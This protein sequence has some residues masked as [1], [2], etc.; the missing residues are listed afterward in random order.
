MFTR[1]IFV[2]LGEFAAELHLP[3][4]AVRRCAG[5]ARIPLF[6]LPGVPDALLRRTD[7]AHLHTL[8]GT[9]G[10]PYGPTAA[11]D[12]PPI[13]RLTIATVIPWNL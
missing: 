11:S 13:R 9:A 3:H 1:T 5:Q 4:A 12:H 10:N 2:P 8:L 6:R 7:A